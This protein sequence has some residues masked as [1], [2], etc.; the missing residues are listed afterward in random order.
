VETIPALRS[1]TLPKAVQPNWASVLSSTPTRT[2]V[3]PAR[4]VSVRSPPS[5]WNDQSMASSTWTRSRSTMQ[6]E[7][8]RP[9]RSAQISDS[10]GAAG[11]A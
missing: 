10:S 1:R 3:S 9:G 11:W 6:V 2:T 5:S 4:K 8:A 7:L